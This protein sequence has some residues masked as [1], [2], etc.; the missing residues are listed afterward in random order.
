MRCRSFVKRVRFSLRR[1][2][3]VFVAFVQSFEGGD[4]ADEDVPDDAN[5]LRVVRP[6]TKNED[7]KPS[8]K[9]VFFKKTLPSQPPLRIVFIALVVVFKNEKKW[10]AE[11]AFERSLYS[12]KKMQKILVL[13]VKA[14]D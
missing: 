14:R 8:T 10:T 1:R 6:P 3:P 2:C 4:A 7:T 11:K 5:D 9:V 12:E 13:D